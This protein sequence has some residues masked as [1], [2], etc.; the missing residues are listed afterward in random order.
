MITGFLLGVIAMASLS[1]SAFFFRFWRR[2][3]DTLFLGFSASFFI[4]ALNRATFLLLDA[5]HEGHP[6][7]YFVRLFSYSLILAAII[8]KNRPRSPRRLL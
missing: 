7:I 4:E 5:P 2:T 6:A 8:Q 3:R 1:A